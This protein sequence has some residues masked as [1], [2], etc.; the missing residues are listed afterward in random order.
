[1]SLTAECLSIDSENYLFSKLN[2]EYLNDF[3]NL[4]SRRQYIDRRKLLYEKTECIRQSMS[5][6][7]NEQVDVFAIDSILWKYARYQENKEIKWARNL[8]IIHPIKA[9][10]LRRKNIFMVINYTVFVPPQGLYNHWI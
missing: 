7:I 6:R 10:V 3:D 1:M 5:E 4:I 9:T 8:N 2:N